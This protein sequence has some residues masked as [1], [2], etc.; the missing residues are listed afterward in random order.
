MFELI[1]R[2]VPETDDRS[3][4][5]WYNNFARAGLFF[6][7]GPPTLLLSTSWGEGVQIEL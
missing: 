3:G 5:S 1:G 4:E 7:G 6:A 2:V